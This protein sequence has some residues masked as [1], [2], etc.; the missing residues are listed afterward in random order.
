MYRTESSEDSRE[1][2]LRFALTCRKDPRHADYLVF[3]SDA[4]ERLGLVVVH[5]PREDLHPLLGEHHYEILGLT[6]ELGLRLAA[7]IL[8][9]AARVVGRIKRPELVPLGSELCRRDPDLKK[10]LVGV[11]A[12]LLDDSATGE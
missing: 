7:E 5:V 11:W 9:D 1:I 8:A 3:S 4:A 6:P 12:T 10:Y 2:A